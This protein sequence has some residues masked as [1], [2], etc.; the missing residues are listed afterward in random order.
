MKTV[1]TVR[2]VDC[3]IILG[4]PHKEGCDREQCVL[5]GLRIFACDCI[6]RVNGL[7]ARTLETVRPDVYVNGP[8]EEMIAKFNGEVA[9]MGGPIVFAGLAY[10][11]L[12]CREFGWFAVRRP[13]D[14]GW[15]QCAPDTAGA[16][17][18]GNRYAKACT[19]GEPGYRWDPMARRLVQDV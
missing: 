11:E 6:Y 19:G 16:L 7:D 14:R 15:V 8:T 9:K 10:G 2:C 18:D 17:P 1:K 13:G 3:G 4:Y 5:C 12:E